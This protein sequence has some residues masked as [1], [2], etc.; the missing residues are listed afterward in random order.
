MGQLTINIAGQ[1]FTAS[2][3]QSFTRCGEQLWHGAIPGGVRTLTLRVSNG[4]GNFD[5]VQLDPAPPTTTTTGTTGSGS[6]PVTA[7]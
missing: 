5:A 4:I 1:N 2:E 7:G 3:S 6:T